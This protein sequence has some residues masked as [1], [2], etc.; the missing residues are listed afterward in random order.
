MKVLQINSVC[1]IRSTGRI[2]TD[3]AKVL[4]SL[5]H[6]CKIAYGR[7][8]VP[9]HCQ[10]YGVRIGTDKDITMHG[11][12]SRLF[13]RT[14]FGSKRATKRF[15][16][17]V[18]AYDP[19]VIHLHNIHGYYIHIG[20][21]FQ[22]LKA[23]GKPVVWTLHDCWAF[24]GHCAYFERIACEKWKTT[25]GCFSCPQKNRYPSSL[26]LDMSARNYK[27]KKELFSDIDNM[28]IVTPSKWLAD[29]TAS[30]FLGCYPI[31]VIHNGIDLSVFRSTDGTFRER[32]GLENKKIVLGVAAAWDNRKGFEDVLQLSAMLDDT[33]AVVVVGVTEQ[34]QQ[35]LPKSV[36]GITR[37]NNAQEL[38]GIYTSAD[39]F[40]NPTY[41]DNYPT[42][43]LEAQ[44]CGTPAITYRTGGSVES[45][46][47]EHI[48]EQ[49]DVKA[50]C[51]KVH[52]VL[53]AKSVALRPASDF[54]ATDRY[55]EYV[56]LYQRVI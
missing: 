22:Y 26:L 7:E 5:G 48:V 13:D 28:T 50:L 1:G 36:I 10:E 16:E 19:D 9:E 12:Y 44:A 38:A 35:A 15:I 51:D 55:H 29:I 11:A 39:V 42:V 46:P 45:V 56:A 47:H 30:S 32:Y 18:K 23:A 49:G 25:R 54:S 14:G 17:W 6:E 41:E 3:I 31:Q 20:E 40:I 52:E 2:C 43:N 34:Q 21:L 33:H 53:C 4:T 8:A 24:T 27:E 37:T